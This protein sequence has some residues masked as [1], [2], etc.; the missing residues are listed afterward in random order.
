MGEEIS[1]LMDGELDDAR[2][3]RR[4]RAAEAVRR[5][6]HLGVL[7]RHRR[8]A[9]RNRRA[10]A[11]ILAPLRGAA[12]G[13][14]DGAR[15]AGR[16]PRGSRPM[17]G[18]PPPA[19]PRSRSSAGWRS[20]RCR[21][22]RRPSPRPARRGRPVG[23]ARRAQ[24]I[25]ADYLQRAPGVLADRPR[26]RASAR[27]CA[28]SRRRPAP[29]GRRRTDR[30][31]PT[32]ARSGAGAAASRRARLLR[33]I[34]MIAFAALA[35]APPAF[36]EDAAAWL[37]RAAAAARDL[38]Y[39]G[40]I[41]YQ[42]GAR[43][44]TSRLVHLN[45][46]G[47]ELEKLVN[48]DGPAREVIRSRGEVRCYYPDAKVLRIE[49]RTF[50]N[51]FPVAVGGRAEGARRVLRVPQGRAGARRRARGAGVDV[52]AE[53]RPALRPQVLGR[54]RHRAAAQGPHLQRARRD[55]RAVRFTDLTIGAK[56]DR[57][58][59]QPT[60]SAASPDWKMLKS[61]LGDIDAER[62]RLGRRQGAAGLLQ[63]GRGLPSAE[64]P[65]RPDRAPRLLGRAGVGV[66]VH[67]EDRTDAAPFDR[68]VAAGRHQR[69]RPAVRGPHR[70]RP[71]RG[72][73]HD[74]SP[75]GDVGLPPLAPL[76][77]SQ[78]PTFATPPRE[79]PT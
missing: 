32:A 15:A 46:R 39:V 16:S 36:A 65:S 70:D 44:E 75:D 18:P 12:R 3:R 53:G 37:A 6:G 2:G 1:R 48:L 10:D 71:R 7:P 42:H 8:R 59:V 73:R 9:A 76:P 56:I 51:A 45:D 78:C 79:S 31:E 28:A 77:P 20:A 23:S 27:T 74:G 19:W 35:I 55:R 24:P 61:P 54:R 72:S 67:R 11:G 60:W 34:A 41:V 57:E 25:P 22:S 50:R 52:R 17:P 26:S 69:V 33:P 64:R 66:G 47:V 63:A 62:H 13:R 43:V 49:P 38:N 58:M 14:A 21:P 68:P 40:T 30:M 4:V 29:P 5:D